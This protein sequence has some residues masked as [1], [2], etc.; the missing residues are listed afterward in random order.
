MRLEGPTR[1]RESESKVRDSR[2]IGRIVALAAVIVG[3]AAVAIVLLNSGSPY[4]VK[5]VFQNASQLVKGDLVQVAG[6]PVGKVTDLALTPDGQAAATLQITDGGYKPLHKGTVATVRQASLSGVANRYVNLTLAGPDAPEIRNGETIPASDTHSAVDLDQLFDIFDPQTRESLRGTIRGFDTLYGARS[7]QL[8][9]AYLFLNPSLASSS[10]LFSELDFDT[11]MLERFITAS[12]KFVTDVAQ[13]RNDL[14]GLIDHLATALGAIGDQKA[15]LAQAIS[16]LPPFMR[17]ANTTFVNLRHALDDLTPLVNASKP[18]APKLR[19]FLAQLRPLA[20]DARPTLRDL[21]ALTLDPQ[22]HN[23][24]VTLTNSTIPVRD[25]AIGPVNVGGTSRP[26]AFPDSTQALL[27]STPE[28]GFARPYAPELTDWFNSFGHSGVYDAL[29]GVARSA[30][31]VNAVALVNGLLTIIPPEL[32]PMAL[33][34]AAS[35]GQRNR[36]PGAVERNPGD[37]STPYHPPGYDCDPTQ[38]P[39]GQ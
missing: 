37:G 3:V 4:K 35:I 28:L 8:A 15:S 32:R 30:P 16:L 1:G 22:H 25:I 34:S 7:Q 18:V 31:S 20:H 5:A 38:I 2:L 10:R 6:A 14:S 27:T 29:G 11:P 9:R 19:R 26:G 33:T 39:P 23:D 24:L 17:R 12:S 36:C 21:A 13:R